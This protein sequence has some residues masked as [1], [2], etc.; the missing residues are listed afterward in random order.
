VGVLTAVA[1][2]S[3]LVAFPLTVGVTDP[4]I[5]AL[6]CLALALAARHRLLGAALAVGVAC[7]M[8]PTAWAVIPVLA[9]LAWAR[10]SRRTAVWF[11]GT[12]VGSAVV[13]ALAAAPGVLATP[14]A[15][16]QNLIDY[17]LGTSR[18]QT[19]ADS[20]LPGHLISQLGHAGHL[21]VDALLLLTV[22]GFAAWLLARPPRDARDAGLRLVVLY[23]AAFTLAPSTRYGYYAYPLA[24]I[25]W[26]A[27]T[28]SPRDPADPERGRGAPAAP[29]APSPV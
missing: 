26:L 13:L 12:A 19:V 20:P 16:R 24:L 14:D 2:A 4:P 10:E 3:P 6:T 8:K 29:G 7:A 28:R 5:I 21:T 9:V 18:Y 22:L 17:P 1:V 11:T 27:L 23:A 15:I 25:G